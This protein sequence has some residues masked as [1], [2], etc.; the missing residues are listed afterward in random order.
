MGP[1]HLFDLASR[2]A[3]WLTVRQAA[4][5]ENVSNVNTP[6]YKAGDV[7]PFES[8][9]DT[10]RLS[11]VTS[12]PR[13]LGLGATEPASFAVEEAPTWEIHH[14]GNS[15]GLEHELMKASEVSGD[16]SLNRTISKAFN[17]MLL[18]SLKG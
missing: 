1:I 3:Q 2:H 6:G 10:T 7:E 17:R 14:S 12:D 15:V 5:A 4:I 8:I 11:I 13:H 18:A 9:S 16:Y